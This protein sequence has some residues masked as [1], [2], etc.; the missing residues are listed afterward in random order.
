[1]GGVD[2]AIEAVEGR[3]FQLVDETKRDAA[4]GYEAPVP[5]RFLSAGVAAAQPCEANEGVDEM[6][7]PG[8]G[9]QRSE[10]MAITIPK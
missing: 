7:I 2:A 10:V 1:M 3:L 4:G 6:R 5:D 9:D 8:D